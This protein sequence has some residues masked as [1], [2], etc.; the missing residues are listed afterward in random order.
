[1]D[2]LYYLSGFL[3]VVGLPLLGVGIIT[4]LIKPHLVNNRRV[5]KSPMS[6]KKIAGVGIAAL[7]MS[8]VGLSSVMAATEPISVK[9][10]RVAREAAETKALQVKQQQ[11]EADAKRKVAE[12]DQARKREEEAN[13]PVVKTETKAEAISFKSIKK[14]DNTLPKGQKKVSVIGVDGKRTITY[15]VTYVRG[16]ETERKEV[17]T[18]VT[19][20]AINEV[21]LIG[22]YVA[23]KPSTVAPKP[24]SKRPA[25]TPR[26][27]SSGGTVKMSRA[28]ICHAP[29]TTYY[30]RTTHYVSYPS[31]SG[32]LSAGGRLPKR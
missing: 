9:Q 28:G 16:E 26:S 13:K 19:K 27:S 20:K 18:K 21:T 5:I 23:P 10:E 12:Q 31:L 25:P 14:N 15:E 29:G 17:K 2:I 30:S 22:T 7:M 32:C 11:Q 6:R 8:L 4:A 24:T 3:T 1:M